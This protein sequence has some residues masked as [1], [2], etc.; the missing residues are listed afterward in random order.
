M[1][2]RKPSHIN[3]KTNFGQKVKNLVELGA[4]LKGI[5]D[6]GKAVYAI[7]SAAAPYVIPLLGL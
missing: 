6:T 4:H 1:L 2:H 7:G 5:Y 3:Y